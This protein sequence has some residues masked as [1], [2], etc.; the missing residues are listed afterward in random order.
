MLF[1]VYETLSFAHKEI[2]RCKLSYGKFK[3]VALE[4]EL[5][6]FKALFALLYLFVVNEVI[7]N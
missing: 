2:V 6:I 1:L 3:L 4:P 5:I 7:Q